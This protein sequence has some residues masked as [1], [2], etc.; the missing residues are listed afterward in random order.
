MKIGY[1]SS[2]VTNRMKSQISLCGNMKSFPVSQQWLTGCCFLG[3][4]FGRENDPIL[5]CPFVLQDF[6]INALC[7]SFR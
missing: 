1:N 6:S 5:I 2:V 4:H 7:F 3:L